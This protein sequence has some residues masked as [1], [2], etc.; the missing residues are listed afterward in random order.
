MNRLEDDVKQQYLAL[1]D[2]SKI[3]ASERKIAHKLKKVL[4][5]AAGAI[6][7]A[8]KVGRGPSLFMSIYKVKKVTDYLFSFLSF[9]FDLVTQLRYYAMQ[10]NA[11]V[12]IMD[13]VQR[14]EQFAI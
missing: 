5:D 13:S 1:K 2:A 12:H 14:K 6:K 7:R 8:L 4:A 9:G 3:V 11:F 10:I